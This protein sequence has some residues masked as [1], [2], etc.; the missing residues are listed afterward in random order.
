MAKTILVID[1][2]NDLRE[3]TAE[4]LELAGYRTLTAE[5]GK[6]GV[7]VAVREKPSLI[8]CDIMMP[9]LDG[10]GVLHLLRKNED[11]AN[12]PFI[13]LT[14]KTERSDFRK[15]MEMGADDYVTKPFE[16]IE[17]L[18]AIEV[19]L[20]KS[21]VLEQKYAPT[22]QGLSQFVRD[23]KDTGLMQHLSEQYAVEQ[24]SKKQN[25]YAES[26]RPRYLYYLVAGKVKAYKTHE[27]GKEYITDLYS[28]GDFVG[29]SALIEDKNYDDTAVIVEDA[30]I[31]QIPREDFLTM[32]H[33]DVNIAAKFIRIITQNV[34]EKEERLLSLAYSS[35]RKRVAKALVDLNQKFN[36]DGGATHAIEISR[37]EIAQYVGTA[38]ESLIRTL[39]DFKSEKLI[40][41]RNGKIVVSD[42]QKLKN[43]LY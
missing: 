9:E 5:N 23:I 11:T 28:A 40:D 18:N 39:S 31:M 10:Y 4:I 3:N 21:E 36:A 12:I 20:K 13:F 19:R 43:L 34:K 14:A 25:L 41:I 26:K 2:N 7:D 17:L 8:V 29:Y 38:T 30:E 22:A 1:D 32:I 6:R 16:D 35:L 24:Y 42:A 37:E 33:S 27:D 15:G